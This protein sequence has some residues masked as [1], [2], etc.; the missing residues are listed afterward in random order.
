[1]KKVLVFI[2]GIS[3][4]LLVFTIFL[5]WWSGAF[6]K[7]VV[8]HEERGPYKIICLPHTGSYRGVSLKILRV[9]ELLV[10]SGK[11]PETSLGTPV[12][13][14]YDNP[15]KVAEEKLRSKGGYIVLADLPENILDSDK[16]LEII[17]IPRRDTVTAKFTGHPSLAAAKIYPPMSKWMTENGFEP[18]GPAVELYQTRHVETEIPVRPVEAKK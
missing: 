8:T 14:Y 3:A 17:D 18:D 5:G 9:H 12:A 16:E 10:E 13:I 2:S 11:V 7:A 6:N 1:M 4:G 15:G